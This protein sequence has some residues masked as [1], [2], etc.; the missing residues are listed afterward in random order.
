MLLKICNNFV[1]HTIFSH[2]QSVLSDCCTIVRKLTVTQFFLRQFGL[3]LG[4]RWKKIAFLHVEQHQDDD[5]VAVQIQVDQFDEFLHEIA[6]LLVHGVRF[7]VVPN[8]FTVEAVDFAGERYPAADAFADVLYGEVR[9][10]V[11][12]MDVLDGP[13]CTVVGEEIFQGV[14]HFFHAFRFF[15]VS[16]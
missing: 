12:F 8:Q 15:R 10:D 2:F 7:D 9:P 14:Q 6:Q 1:E 4:N 5:D 16:S 3:Q 13:F 11:C